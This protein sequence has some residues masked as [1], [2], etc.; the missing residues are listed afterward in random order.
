M[1]DSYDEDSDEYLDD[2]YDPNELGLLE[3]LDIAKEIVD[4][5]RYY[6]WSHGLDMLMSDKS[7]ETL[8]QLIY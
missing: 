5:L 7:A 6:A 3:K 2:G 4:K 1:T 8:T